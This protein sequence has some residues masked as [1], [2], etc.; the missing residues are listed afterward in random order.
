MKHRFSF[1]LLILA[2]AVLHPS[3]LQAAHVIADGPDKVTPL[4]AGVAAPG[5]VVLGADGPFDLGKLLAHKPTILVFYSSS[6]S[7]LGHRALSDLRDGF[8]IYDSLGF[9]VLAISADAP[10]N[11]RAAVEKNRINYPLL[12]DQDLAL[13]SS[14]GIAFRAPKELV[15]SSAEQ[16]ISLPVIPGADGAA[17]QLVPS[18]FV[19][20]RNGI[21]RWVYSNPHRNP[22][23]TQIVAAAVR[24][25]K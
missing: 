17:G 11:L 7:R 8:P 12:S 23:Q 4:A 25:M 1:N 3:G 2:L 15:S 22:T 5:G 13:A 6:G 9:Q 14:Y 10:E 16:G 20:D 18:V 24:A 19:V 21:I